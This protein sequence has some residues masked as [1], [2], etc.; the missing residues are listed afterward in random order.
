MCSLHTFLSTHGAPPAYSR[1][2]LAISRLKQVNLPA[3]PKSPVS[4][5]HWPPKHQQC[6]AAPQCHHHALSSY[7]HCPT[8]GAVHACTDH[9]PAYNQLFANANDTIYG[10]IHGW[11]SNLLRC[12]LFVWRI[13]HYVPA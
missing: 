5:P 6:C 3:F 10:V 8:P 11:F 12:P 1:S 4:P 2:R 7:W 13:L 9:H